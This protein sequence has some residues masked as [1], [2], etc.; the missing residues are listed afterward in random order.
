M[1]LSLIETILQLRRLEQLQFLHQRLDLR[2]QSKLQLVTVTIAP[3]GSYTVPNQLSTP[4]YFEDYGS[5]TKRAA[6]GMIMVDSRTIADGQ[7]GCKYGNIEIEGVADIQYVPSWVGSGVIKLDGVAYVP[8]DAK[9][10][11]SGNIKKLGGAAETVAVAETT[12]DLFKISG[13]PTVGITAVTINDGNLFGIGGAAE[14]ATF[15]PP[16]E[17][18]LLK[19]TGSGEPPLLVYSEFFFWNSILV[20][21]W[22][23]KKC[24][25][26]ERKWY[27]QTTCKKTRNLRTIRTCSIYA[28]RLPTMFS[29]HQSWR[30]KFLLFILNLVVRNSSAL[31]SGRVPRETYRGIRSRSLL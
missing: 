20:C 3:G 16:E 8:L 14:S 26:L 28:G 4:Q 10:R 12:T 29:I 9:I 27:Y 21:W 19:F 13:T 6:P 5:V 11:G 30:Y 1:V 17:T 22:R 24:I 23:R 2:E 25:C 7:P 18:P 31:Q 15:N